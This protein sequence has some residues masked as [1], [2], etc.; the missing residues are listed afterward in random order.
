M[1]VAIGT[2]QR[3]DRS[4][5]GEPASPRSL[6]ASGPL[7]APGRRTGVPPGLVGIVAALGL[8]A[9]IAAWLVSAHPGAWRDRPAQ[10]LEMDVIDHP[11]PPPPAE[12]PPPPPPEP[13]RPRVRRVVVKTAPP[14]EPPTPANQ[15]PPPSPPAA[16][17][18]PVFGVTIDSVVTGDSAVALPVGNTLM[19]KDRS[20]GRPTPPAAATVTE[21]PPAFAP[22]AETSI[23]EFPRTLHE[24]KGDG[25]YPA[26][27]RRMG[28]EG[29]VKLRVAIDRR[30]N[31]RSV[32][33]VS[34]AGYGFDEA[35][36]RAMWKFKF[37]PA[38]TRDGEAVDFLI[39]YTYIFRAER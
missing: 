33:V 31:I 6:P 23:G 9:G 24:E 3:S 5:R 15:E 1:F 10:T 38:R 12:E 36:T 17:A 14:P 13:P 20:P 7:P 30:G 35:A 18:P 25:Y 39:T 16:P 28:L 21:G 2:D 19:T 37:T 22:V 34:R 27:A 29:Q 11:P 4:S 32:R 8:H 26:E